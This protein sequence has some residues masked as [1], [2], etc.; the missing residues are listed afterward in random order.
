MPSKKP[1]D[2][3]LGRTGGTSPSVSDEQL[4]QSDHGKLFT[5]DGLKAHDTERVGAMTPDTDPPDSGPKTYPASARP[6]S[7]RSHRPVR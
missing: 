4:A 2:R 5:E 6:K 3:R 1:P 7:R